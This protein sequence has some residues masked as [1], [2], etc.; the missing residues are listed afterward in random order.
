[1]GYQ[2]LEC[3]IE[4]FVAWLTKFQHSLCAV[5]NFWLEVSQDYI[6]S[7][8]SYLRLK[9]KQVGLNMGEFSF[10]NKRLLEKTT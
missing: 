8:F 4:H 3:S 10:L 9:H 6:M 2:I 1:M 7:R 5:G